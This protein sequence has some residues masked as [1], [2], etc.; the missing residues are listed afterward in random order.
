MEQKGSPPFTKPKSF[1]PFFLLLEL[2]ATKFDSE[3]ICN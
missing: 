2:I 3:M 1:I